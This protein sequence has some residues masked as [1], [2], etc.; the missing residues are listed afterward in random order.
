MRVTVIGSGNMGAA[1][2]KQIA[3][4]R[5]SLV[6]TGRNSAKAKDLAQTLGATYQATDA[7]Q[8]ADVVILATPYGEALYAL[9]FAGKLQGKTVIDITNPLTPDYMGLTIGHSTSA[10]EQIQKAF[11]E[12][13]VVK[14]FNTVFAQVLAQGA[15]LHGATVPV[16]VA[17]D[18]AS[19]KE[20]AKALIQSMGFAPIDAGALKNARYLEPLAGLNIYFGY[21]AGHG[22]SIAPAWIGMG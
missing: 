2:A 5:H 6:I 4:A 9:R 22:T 12:A 14:A 3:K 1:L 8:G 13:R 10:A 16:F 7:S 11:P 21:G 20:T 17:A 18:D 19:A 15:S